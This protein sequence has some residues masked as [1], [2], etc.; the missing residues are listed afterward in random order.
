MLPLPPG[1]NFKLKTPIFNM[2]KS[3]QMEDKLLTKEYWIEKLKLGFHPDGG[4]FRESYR[5]DVMVKQVGRE[6]ITPKPAATSIYY[7]VDSEC[8]SFCHLLKSDEMWYYHLGAP[9]SIFIIHDDGS[10]ETRTLGL[11]EDKDLCVLIPRNTWFGAR[12]MDPG[13]FVVT[14]CAVAPGFDYEDLEM[15]DRNEMV[16]L[17]PQHKETIIKFTLTDL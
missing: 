16:K 13:K 5:S 8:K 1:G 14:S 9:L 4:H 6:T 15:A 7:L 2:L 11:G 12:V 10:L 17:F 3:I